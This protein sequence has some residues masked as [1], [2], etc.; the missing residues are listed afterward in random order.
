MGSAGGSLQTAMELYEVRSQ[1]FIV[2]VWL[3]EMEDVQRG[4][5]WLG[6]VTH[7]P[8]GHQRY[9]HDLDSITNFLGGYLK[10]M[11]VKHP[12]NNWTRLWPMH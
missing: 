9:V 3:E 11:G 8:D 1:S 6:L 12:R 2:R 7:V 4:A 10:G 5:R